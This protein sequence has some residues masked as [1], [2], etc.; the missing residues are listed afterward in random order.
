MSA[1]EQYEMFVVQ[2]LTMILDNHDRGLY[3]RIQAEARR[4]VMEDAGYD[5][6]DIDTYRSAYRN[7]DDAFIGAVG[8]A[9][10]YLIGDLIE[11]AELPQP[12]GT[13]LAGLLDLHTATVRGLLGEHYLPEVADMEEL[14]SDGEIEEGE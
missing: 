10:A 6:L 11:E 9:V 8:V 12:W 4:A 1:R 3:E 14:L 13:V 2:P 5:S 7:R